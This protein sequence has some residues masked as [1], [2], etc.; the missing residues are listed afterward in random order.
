MRRGESGGVVARDAA[1]GA[2]AS[3]V[4][5]VVPLGAVPVFVSN[6]GVEAY[7]LIGLLTAISTA[8]TVVTRG[9][10]RALQREVAA[11]HEDRVRL[12]TAAQ[13]WRTYEAAALLGATVLVLGLVA[14]AG[15]MASA[16]G[17]TMDPGTV[18][19][20]VL[21]LTLKILALLPYALYQAVLLGCGRQVAANAAASATVIAG[22]GAAATVAATTGSLV[23][24]VLA[25]VTAWLLISLVLRAAAARIL[26]VSAPT[27]KLLGRAGM[28][29][30]LPNA[31]GLMW[32]HGTGVVIGQADRG[33]VAAVLSLRA[34]GAYTPAATA[35]RALS[36]S[37]APLLSAVFP[38]MCRLADRGSHTQLRGLTRQTA[39]LTA[40]TSGVAA[41]LLVMFAHEILESWTRSR[42]IADR[43]DTPL[44]IAACAG[45]ALGQADLHLHLQSASG[46][47][48]AGVL[49]NS[50]ALVWV[51]L[52]CVLAVRQLGLAGASLTWLAYASVS[53]AALAVASSRVLRSPAVELL[54]ATSQ[55]VAVAALSVAGAAAIVSLTGLHGLAFAIVTAVVAVSAVGSFV[56]V[57]LRRTSPADGRDGRAQSAVKPPSTTSS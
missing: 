20:C 12:V 24:T 30:R 29:D 43:A 53:W 3:V 23:M 49:V 47:T 15:T 25:D 35:G 28:R 40:A 5:A 39:R 41:L 27:P 44:M 7:G 13:A 10:G 32:T 37:Y 51:P 11:A 8:S 2:A 56:L 55:G 34:L 14:T 26:P 22:T 45:F 33:A 50:A 42:E 18:R 46:R 38:R 17:G 19:T 6:L 4:A 1:A 16:F 31:A 57:E 54:Y 48:R 9:L 36:I 52:G 21:L